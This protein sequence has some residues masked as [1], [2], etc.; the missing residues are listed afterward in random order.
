MDT[1]PASITRALTFELIGADGA[2]TPLA[3]ELRYDAYDPYAVSACFR[4]GDTHV[5]WVFARDLLAVGTSDP[6][7]D[8]DVHIYPSLDARGR[9]VTTIELSSPDG[10]AIIQARTDELCDFLARTEAMVATGNESDHINLDTV[11]AQ[12]LAEENATEEN[13]TE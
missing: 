1:V 5:R 6:S 11:L 7:G 12:I 2:A 4:S 13:A 9:A 8:G 10:E 3:A